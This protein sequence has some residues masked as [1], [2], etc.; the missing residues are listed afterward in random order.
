[1]I[2]PKILTICAA[3]NSRSV[4]LAWLLKQ[5]YKKEAIAIG[6]GNSSLDTIKMLCEWADTIILTTREGGHPYLKS[7]EVKDKV[8]FCDVGRDRYFR[9]FEQDLID[10]YELFIEDKLV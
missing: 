10:Q 2:G 6:M 4:C 3:G 7:P 9:G 1:M 5:K 8:L